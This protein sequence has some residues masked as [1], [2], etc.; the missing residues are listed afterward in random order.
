MLFSL[1]IATIVFLEWRL[2]GTV[3]HVFGNC[4]YTEPSRAYK[5]KEYDVCFECSRLLTQSTSEV[6]SG[7]VRRTPAGQGQGTHD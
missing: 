4:P 5:P 7:A 3:F 1:L 2:Q 6:A